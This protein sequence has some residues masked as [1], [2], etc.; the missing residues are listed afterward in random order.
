MSFSVNQASRYCKEPTEVEYKSSMNIIQY[1]KCTKNKSI[2]YSS[3][4]ESIDYSDSDFACNELTRKSNRGYIYLL[5]DSPISWKTQLERNVT[6][7]IAKA[8][9]VSLTRY[10]V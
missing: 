9:F 2:Y 4:N 3:N 1:L 6:L 8:E 10:V 5:R 7:S